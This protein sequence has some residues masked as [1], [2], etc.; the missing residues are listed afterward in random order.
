VRNTL[1]EYLEIP[2]AFEVVLACPNKP[3]LEPISEFPEQQNCR[4]NLHKTEK[5]LRM[6]FPAV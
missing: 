3:S 2:P 4:R 6:K 5:I 1:V